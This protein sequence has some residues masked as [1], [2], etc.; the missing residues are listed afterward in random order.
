MAT[1]GG[2]LDLVPMLAPE[3]AALLDLLRGLTAD[4]WERPTECPGWRVKGIARHVLGDDLS[5]LSR[6]RDASVDGL[7]LFAVDRAGLGFRALLDGFNEQWVTASGF[8]STE[9]LLELLRLVGVWSEEFY[10]AVGLDTVSREPV[11]LF[12][13]T[14]PSP[15]WQ[16]IAREYTERFVH[17]SQIRRAVGAPALD[18]E[19][20]TAA[21]RVV[22]HILAAW[23]RDLAPANGTAIAIDFGDVGTWTLRR[24][25]D[26]WSASDGDTEPTARI[27]VAPERAAA[28]LSRGLT[29]DEVATS[30]TVTGDA[31]LA[32]AALAIVVPLIGRP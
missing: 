4:D 28:I 31:S 8:L 12:A 10:A 21:A 17:Q 27:A 3:R 15:Y 16:V 29:T 22:A 26:R 1:A 24:E 18:G 32:R 13:R 7:T 14:T 25:D 30:T 11:G 19:L 9:L 23:L 5:L 2:T 20:V 6:Q